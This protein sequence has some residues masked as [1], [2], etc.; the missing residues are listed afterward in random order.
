LIVAAG[1]AATVLYS[2]ASNP[3]LTAPR[4]ARI[5]ILRRPVLAD[6]A[7]DEVAATL[8]FG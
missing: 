6:L 7:V 2:A 5:A 8:P 3:D 4:G 1:C